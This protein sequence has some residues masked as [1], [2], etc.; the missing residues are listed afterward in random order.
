MA[1][2]FEGDTLRRSG[3][4]GS[5]RERDVA[6]R[7]AGRRHLP[8]QTAGKPGSNWPGFCNQ[9]ESKFRGKKEIFLRS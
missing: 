5:A 9:H 2:F 3:C 4:L 7:V 1:C 6:G 8:R